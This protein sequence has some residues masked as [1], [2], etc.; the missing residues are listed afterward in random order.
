M[1]SK[2]AHLSPGFFYGV[3]ALADTFNARGASVSGEDFLAVWLAESGIQ[4]NIPNRAGFP[5]YGLNQMGVSEMRASGFQ[6][7]PEEWMSLTPEQ[8]LPY[9][10]RFYERNIKAFFGDDYTK[11]RG[12]AGQ[13]YAINFL[14][15]FSPR[16]ED[17]D[18]GLTQ[19]GEKY[20]DSN[21]SLD[22]DRDGVITGRDL[23]AAVERAKAGRAT[24]WNEVRARYYAESGAPPPT[25]TFPWTLALTL[26]G[27]G[28]IGTL[29]LA[30]KRPDLLPHPVRTTAAGVLAAIPFLPP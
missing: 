8:Q 22:V 12:G 4:S 7:S 13:L 19:R 27:V 1:T 9:V 16:A 25:K 2:T 20:Y 17:P 14:P 24:Y 10:K 23:T 3:K 28:A 6:G 29:F 18:S 5:Y 21:V 11:L 26:L 30:R 15:A